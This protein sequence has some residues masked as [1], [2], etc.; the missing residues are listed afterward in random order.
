MPTLQNPDWRKQAASQ[1]TDQEVE[2][3]FLD[4]AY[5][6]IQNKATPLMKPPYRIGFEIVYKNDANSKMIGLFLF[7]VGDE[8]LYAPVF[9]INGGI[10]GT[11]L[12][13]RYRSKKFNPN[14]TE[15]VEYIMGL[16][17]SE[18]GRPV[19]KSVTQQAGQDGIDMKT[20]A[21]P[22]DYAN[23]RKFASFEEL[24]SK[25]GKEIFTELQAKGEELKEA[26]LKQFIVEDGGY[27]AV[28]SITD[29]MQKDA[30]FARAMTFIAGEENFMPQ[31][32]HDSY[33]E[34]LTKKAAPTDK[35][36]H[37]HFGILNPNHKQA[38]EGLY[39]RG[40]S[41]ED[42]RDADSIV[43]TVIEN[44]GQQISSPE[45]PGVYKLLDVEGKSRD[46]LVV[47]DNHKDPAS[48]HDYEPYKGTDEDP[49]NRRNPMADL[50]YDYNTPVSS[51]GSSGDKVCIDLDSHETVRTQCDKLVC[52]ESEQEA[53]PD[54]YSEKLLSKLPSL[55]QKGKI[56]RI[57]DANT[58]SDYHMS[59]S[60]TFLVHKIEKSDGVTTILVVPDYYA[61]DFKNNSNYKPSPS[62]IYKVILNPEYEGHNWDKRVFQP[63]N[64]LFVECGERR[65][66]LKLA[67]PKQLDELLNADGELKEAAIYTRDHQFLLREGNKTSEAMSKLAT[68]AVLMRDFNF[69]HE[70]AEA[71]IE[72]AASAG[73][74]K[75]RYPNIKAAYNLSFEQPP[76]FPEDMDE[77]FGVAR[78]DQPL[79]VEVIANQD[80]PE[81]VSPRVG[82]RVKF[83]SVESIGG[84]G[85]MELAQLSEQTGNK[86][87]FDH[88][89]IGSLSKTYNSSIMIDKWIPDLETALDRIGR[90]I[91]L[92]YWKPEDFADLYGED[93]QTG[94][95]NMLLS[96]FSSYGELVLEILKKRKAFSDSVGNSY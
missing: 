71:V 65:D 91:F 83:D 20:L 92:F 7:K 13:Y 62:S 61:E 48:N 88:G 81:Q 52:L 40:Y 51:C 75:F 29:H 64:V 24:E 33:Q 39:K 49:Y 68:L 57:L 93:D 3:A 90:M 87:L 95:E 37:I 67:D 54:T 8:L 30:S 11:D 82:D 53:E 38:S 32:L 96:T 50:K 56:Y 31:E 59:V 94:L 42:N 44:D 80:D 15:W 2:K 18:V 78:E 5:T 63:D 25:P 55:P 6:F 4:Q 28:Q 34:E 60:D 85:P 17:Q 43:G 9:F 36:V 26:A 86:A 41:V 70:V 12:L 73:Q 19:S 76:E 69:G 46:C 35:G 1:Y 27:N 79:S 89:V 84:A 14:T 23:A 16:Q 45:G 21:Y 22:P 58:E 10:K 66:D 74:F 47:D 72:K 77:T